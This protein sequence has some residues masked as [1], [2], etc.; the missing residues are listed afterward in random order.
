M[1]HRDPDNLGVPE[2]EREARDIWDM[3]KESRGHTQRDGDLSAV[4]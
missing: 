2:N 3:R 4:Q 1:W